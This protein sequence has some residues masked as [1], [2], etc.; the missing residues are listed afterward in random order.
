MSQYHVPVMLSQT[1]DFLQV[2]AGG[3][4]VDATVGGGGHSRA[5]MSNC[6]HIRLFCFD[7]D[8]QAIVESKAAL[9]EWDDQVTLI[10]ENFYMIRTYLALNKV[11]GIDGIVFDLGVSSH[12]IDS[13]QR[14]F[15]FEGDAPLDMRMD[16]RQAYNAWNVVNELPERQLELVFRQYG[17]ENHSRRIALAIVKERTKSAICSTSQLAEIIGKNVKGSPKDVI[18]SKARIFQSIRIYLNQEL[19]AL[20]VALR[21]AI[22]ILKPGGR[23]V[24]LS[25]HSL[26]DR[27]VK[28]QFRNT[29]G[30]CK[31]PLES[32]QCMC[33]IQPKIKILTSRPVTVKEDEIE[34]NSRARSAKLRAAERVQGES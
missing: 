33:D 7:R 15:S 10:N 19:D 25:Y 11:K 31:C 28:Q 5:I 8:P 29:S 13:I 32:P 26:E 2:R 3:T 34:R 20:Q 1:L 9:S 17:E 12:Q 30:V 27:L 22:N 21:D 14:G 16:T 4:Y 6:G 24:V 18:K 23:I